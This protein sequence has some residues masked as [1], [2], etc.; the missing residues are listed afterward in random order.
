[1]RKTKGYKGVLFSADVVREAHQT[2]IQLL[3]E[4]DPGNVT[5]ELTHRGISRGNERWSFDSDEEFFAEYRQGFTSASYSSGA[6]NKVSSRGIELEFS[7]SSTSANVTVETKER[8]DIERVFDVFERHLAESAIPL[9]PTP[10]SP[11]PTVLLAIVEVNN[12]VT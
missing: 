3:E 4:P 11:P 6:F 2:A 10:E 7:A 12:G 5:R 9:P 8:R 1:M